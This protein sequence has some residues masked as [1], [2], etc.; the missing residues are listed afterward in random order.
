MCPSHKSILMRDRQP[1]GSIAQTEVFEA[2]C[3]SAQ[4]PSTD[5]PINFFTPEPVPIVTPGFIPPEP[6]PE[7]NFMP[8]PPSPGS[9]FI[10]PQPPSGMNKNT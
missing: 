8:L 4:V 9:N 5:P 6:S 3:S 1:V 7:S 2:T 10:H